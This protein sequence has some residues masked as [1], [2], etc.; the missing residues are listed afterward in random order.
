MWSFCT[1]K[2]PNAY[3]PLVRCYCMFLYSEVPQCLQ[4][5]GTVLLYVVPSIST[6]VQGGRQLSASV[7]PQLRRCGHNLF[8]S[9]RQTVRGNRTRLNQLHLLHD[10]SAYHPGVTRTT[11]WGPVHTTSLLQ[12]ELLHSV[13]IISLTD[14]YIKRLVAFNTIVIYVFNFYLPLTSVSAFWLLHVLNYCLLTYLLTYSTA[15]SIMIVLH[16]A[17]VESA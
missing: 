13:R 12:F 7:R 14:C 17:R 11:R 2:C 3:S 8:W 1:L 4:S 10:L 5:V 15:I 6:I 9:W 16:S